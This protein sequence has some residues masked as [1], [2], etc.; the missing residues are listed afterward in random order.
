MLHHIGIT[1]SDSETAVE[2]FRVA[3]GGPAA[4]PYVKSGPAVDAV[5]G[6]PG[7]R[8]IQHF[9][10]PPSGNG[11]IELLEYRGTPDNRIDPDNGNIGT[12]HPAVVVADMEHT[13]ERLA[14]LGYRPTS[15]PQIATSG[16]IEGYRYVYVIGPDSIRVEL[17]EEP[18]DQ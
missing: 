18:V 17:L 10:T 4:G 8:I 9:V 1:V 2:F 13:L 12:A 6:Y 3:T 5:T 11:V 14:E 16:P 7:A 15:V